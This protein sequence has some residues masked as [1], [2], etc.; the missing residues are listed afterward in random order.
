M[1]PT[2]LVARV[3][4]RDC[5]NSGSTWICRCGRRPSLRLPEAYTS[6]PK[7]GVRQAQTFLKFART[8]S[9]SVG[10][11]PLISRQFE[12]LAQTM[13]WLRDALA[14][15]VFSSPWLVSACRSAVETK[16]TAPGTLTSATRMESL[17]LKPSLARAAAI[18]GASSCS[19]VRSV[20]MGAEKRVDGGH[21]APP[22]LVHSECLK[23]FV[24]FLQPN[25][26]LMDAYLACPESF[27]HLEDV[28]L[29]PVA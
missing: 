9:R 28:R 5:R 11:V 16:R 2:A 23:L 27:Q 6:P 22:V 17:C 21:D 4:C 14:F 8:A 12:N 19:P 25:R 18:R 7:A 29:M 13:L 10:C 20:M 15:H 24:W 3:E 1:R 26:G